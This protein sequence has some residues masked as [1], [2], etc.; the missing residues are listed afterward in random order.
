MP[1]RSLLLQ[2]EDAETRDSWVATMNKAIG[3]YLNEGQR[4]SSLPKDDTSSTSS[5]TK[6]KNRNSPASQIL[7]VEGN[8]KCADCNCAE[9]GS[10]SWSSINLGITIC[11]NCSGIHRALGVHVR[12]VL[13]FFSIL[14]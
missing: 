11:I 5:N 12:S 7:Q 9:I 4:K 6:V 3:F 13:K 10:V 14:N 2:A 8:S 1:N